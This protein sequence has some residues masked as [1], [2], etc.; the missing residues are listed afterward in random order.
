MQS[1]QD[2]SFFGASIGGAQIT[3]TMPGS[4]ENWIDL[5]FGSKLLKTA[6]DIEALA[7]ELAARLSQDPQPELSLNIQWLKLPTGATLVEAAKELS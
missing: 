3:V 4:S 1:R 7:I 5:S 6:S 2:G